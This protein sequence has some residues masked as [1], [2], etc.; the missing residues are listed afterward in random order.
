LKNIFNR[1][2]ICLLAVA[3]TPFSQVLK[4]PRIVRQK[5]W[6]PAKHQGFVLPLVLGLG[7]AVLILGLTA[8]LVTQVD[9]SVASTRQRTSTSLAVAEGAV[10]RL[11]LQFSKRHN[12]LLLGRDYDPIDPRTGKNFLGPDRLPNSGDETTTAIN[13][14]DMSGDP[15]ALFPCF[16]QAGVGAAN[17]LANLRG[18]SINGGTFQL[19]AY[20]YNPYQQTG[21]LLV[22]GTIGDQTTTLLVTFKATPDLQNF[23]GVAT[24]GDRSDTNP[25]YSQFILRGRSIT[26]TH[27]N[28]YY[29]PSTS[30]IPGLTGITTPADPNRP[31]FLP[32]I[33]SGNL[34]GVTNDPIAG[35]IFACNIDFSD[36]PYHYGP[37]P[38]TLPSL[39][40]ITTSTT[41]TGTAGTITNYRVDSIN[42][43]NNDTL[44]VDTTAG[45]VHLYFPLIPGSRPNR[46]NLNN[47][48]KIRN[49]R[50]DNQPPRV[51]DL[52]IYSTGF[53][54]AEGD[55]IVL[56]EQSCIE[57][58]FLFAPYGE[59]V[60][61][62]TGGG[63]PTNP[64]ANIVGVA[65]QEAILSSKNNGANRNQPYLGNTEHDTVITPNATAGIQVAE[66][67]SSLFDTLKYVRAP[68]RYQIGAVQNWQQVRQ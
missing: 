56:R 45:P 12:S 35:K 51:G 43:A 8:A 44:I 62:T 4:F 29:R 22:T 25:N 15:P 37:D 3:S 34:D 50:T 47:N 7:V 27:A 66:D 60:L 61:L 64:Q 63:C 11:L 49:I 18:T 21:H 10:D 13:E 41:I 42:L 52:R 19:L 58:A 46:I 33:W 59:L 30:A 57:N 20:R 31:N 16:Q 5:Q 55:R 38:L 26:G 36:F 65:W 6:Y 39:G 67:V 14:W 9:R 1:G 53:D 28:L 23:P 40:N 48:A 68:I 54:P 32:A 24:Q 17:L 2:Y